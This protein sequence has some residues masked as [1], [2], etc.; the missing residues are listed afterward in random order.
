MI[1]V[2]DH[3]REE[4]DMVDIAALKKANAQRWKDMVVD[5]DLVKTIDKVAQRLVAASAKAQYQ[6]VSNKTGVPWASSR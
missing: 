4:D 1:A 6:S 2:G 5:P 3:A